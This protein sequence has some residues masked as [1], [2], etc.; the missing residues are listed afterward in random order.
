VLVLD[1]V[2]SE[3]DPDRSHALLTALPE[4]QTIL[5]TASRLPEGAAPELV[6]D[7]TDGAVRPRR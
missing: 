4:G 3:L 1:D 5:T 2:F 6:V 7:I